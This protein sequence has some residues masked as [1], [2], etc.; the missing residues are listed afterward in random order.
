MGEQKN[1]M[2]F[3]CVIS[4][5]GA[6]YVMKLWLLRFQYHT[7]ITRWIFA[8]TSLLSFVLTLLAVSYQ[9][10]R[11]ATMNPVKSLRAE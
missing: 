7:E 2:H 11:A 1:P 4:I 5:P 10:I 6:W 9:S 8:I 3:G